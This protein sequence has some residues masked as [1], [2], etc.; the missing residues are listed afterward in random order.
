[1]HR[2]SRILIVASL[3]LCAIAAVAVARYDVWERIEALCGTE[4]WSV[5]TGT[6]PDAR[7][8]NLGTVVP[9]T[10]A[11][12][13]GWTYPS[14]LPRNN[15]VAPYE[16]TVW[17]L[18]VTL[19]KFKR[20]TDED[21]HLVLQDAAG[22]TMIG[23]IPAP[24][25]VAANSPFRAG[26]LN[27]R[28]QF[29]ARYTPGSSFRTVNIPVKVTGVGFFDFPHG[30]TG[31]APNQIELHPILDIVFN[32]TDGNPPPPPSGLNAQASS[33]KVTLVWNASST[34]TS[35]NVYRGLSSGGETLYQTGVTDTFF[36]DTGVVNGT[37]YYYTVTASSDFGESGPSG[38]VSATP[39]GGGGGELISNPGF[40]NGT[41]YAPWV[42]TPSVIDNS[43]NPP[44]HTGSWKAWLDGYGYTHT[45]TLY[46]QVTIPV[47]ATTATLSFWLYIYTDETTTTIPYDT[48]TV[49]VLS[50]S[51][52]VL[53][54]LA[55][56]SNL[57]A[58][59]D[60]ALQTFDL[61]AFIGQTIR[62]NLVGKE[63]YQ[64]Q[65]SFLVDDFSVAYQ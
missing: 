22:N 8:V 14:P 61:S 26:V 63:D 43:A 32:P 60:Y 38:E 50:P 41:N 64:K 11:T 55:T 58:N 62:I 54:T 65:T 4:R 2:F 57:D 47:T 29:D 6:D 23:E 16:T 33:G 30:Q 9:N 49:Q 56:Y 18:R 46:Q 21:Y 28:A 42:T 24:N 17:S 34:A 10:I 5:K 20:E 37:T 7:M 31:A 19:V 25:C 1:M 15:R 44:A 3:A 52:A 40:E 45:D 12:M 35:Y 53:A 36:G 13:V 39:S 59:A 27:A 48:L 51:N